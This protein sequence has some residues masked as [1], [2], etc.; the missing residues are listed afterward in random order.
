VLNLSEKSKRKKVCAFDMPRIEGID[1]IR[2]LE[3]KVKWQE[4]KKC[5]NGEVLVRDIQPPTH[6]KKEIFE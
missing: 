3:T 5:R 6:K 1:K 4:I 2:I